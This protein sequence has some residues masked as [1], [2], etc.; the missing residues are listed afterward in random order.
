[1]IIIFLL[2]IIIGVGILMG[3]IIKYTPVNEKTYTFELEEGVTINKKRNTNA[4]LN[5][6]LHNV[7]A[8]KN[9]NGY[10][11]VECIYNGKTKFIGT[12]ASRSFDVNKIN[13]VAYDYLWNFSRIRR[14][15]NQITFGKSSSEMFT[16]LFDKNETSDY[17]AGIWGESY[18]APWLSGYDA[19]TKVVPSDDSSLDYF[20]AKNKSGLEFMD[21]LT[22][23]AYKNSTFRYFF[24]FDVIDDDWTFGKVFNMLLLKN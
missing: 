10:G 12:V 16:N 22:K 6:N 3:L 15:F 11:T 2:L 18:S 21:F 23:G 5:I 8:I 24:W 9:V 7:P 1:M 17:V 4:T 13:I 20:N 19:I 14:S